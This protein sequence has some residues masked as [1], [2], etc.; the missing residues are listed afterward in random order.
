MKA[1]EIFF[2]GYFLN[3]TLHCIF[4]KKWGWATLYG[5]VTLLNA[6]VAFV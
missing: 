3:E 4:D 2:M 6:I 1:F 5:S